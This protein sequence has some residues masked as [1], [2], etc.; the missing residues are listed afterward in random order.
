VGIIRT[1]LGRGKGAARKICFRCYPALES[2]VRVYGHPFSWLHRSY[3]LP[4]RVEDVAVVLGDDP[5]GTV[6]VGLHVPP[7]S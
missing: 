6:V 7:S 4:L 3:G 1:E 5:Y 2:I